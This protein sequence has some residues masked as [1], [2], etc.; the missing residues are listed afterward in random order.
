MQLV[1]KLSA[2]SVIGNILAL[3]PRETTVVDG[4]E[5][6][7]IVLGTEIDLLRVIGVARGIKRGTTNFGEW[8]AFKGQFEGVRLDD[9]EIF[10]S[11]D[12]FLPEVATD[13]LVP[14]VMEHGEEGV[15]FAFTIGARA[16]ADR[17]APEIVKYE[18]IC[19]PLVEVSQTDPLEAFKNTLPALPAPKAK[20]TPPPLENAAA[21]GEAVAETATATTEKVK[22][23]K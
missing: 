17:A 6:K 20:Q 18:F 1:K 23:K 4:K 9:G 19:K 13:M 7:K 22:A 16:V 14:V 5:I 8:T 10:R 2:K 15:Q 21:I 11:S 3:F 12:L